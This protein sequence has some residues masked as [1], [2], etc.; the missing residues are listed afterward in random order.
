M[1]FSEFLGKMQ[2]LL[3]AFEQGDLFGNKEVFTEKSTKL[4]EDFLLAQ[5]YSIGKPHKYPV[6]IETSDDLIKMFYSGMRNIY[7][8]HLWSY[9]DE[10]QDRAIAKAFVEKRAQDDCV[11]HQTALQQCGLIIQT[12][13][14]RPDVFKFETA[15]S[16][17]IFGQAE[18]G[19]IT[20][21]AVSI[22][23]KQIAKD[24]ALATERL[25]D[26]LTEE[27]EEKTP[28]KGLSLEELES[29]T[30]KLEDKYGKKEERQ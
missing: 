23:N 10:K 19:W 6:K 9:Y 24:E 14:A 28:N 30:K 3:S 13:F 29:I 16:F 8:N 15:P 12:V 2:K 1:E 25:C 17:G 21:R 7:P 26:K 11:S 18:M 22:I 27:I 5:G 4:C 20:D